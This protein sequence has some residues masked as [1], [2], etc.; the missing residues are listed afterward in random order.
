MLLVA[1][2]IVIIRGCKV[3]LVNFQ[4]S[5]REGRMN[6]SIVTISKSRLRLGLH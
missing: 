5:L 4:T 1:D 6:N 3:Y 2:I